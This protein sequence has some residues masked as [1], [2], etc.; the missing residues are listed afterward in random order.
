MSV[1]F[2]PVDTLKGIGAVRSKQLAGMG[3]CTLYDLLSYFPRS[4]EDRTVFTSIASLEPDVRGCFR[5]MVVSHPQTA[6][7]KKGMEITKVSVSDDTKKL[8][9]VFFNQSYISKQ[10]EYGQEYAFYGKLDAGYTGLQMASPSFEPLGKNEITGRIF[11]IYPLSAGISN[12]IMSGIVIQSLDACRGELPDI[13]P[14]S[15]RSLNGLDDVQTAY[16]TVHYPPNFPALDRAKNRLVFE[17]FFVFSV[18]LNLMKSARTSIF[19]SPYEMVNLDPFYGAL[20]FSLTNAQRCATEDIVS[21]FSQNKPM[22]RLIQGDVGSGKTMVAAAAIYCAVKNGQQVA[23]MAPTSILA[24][25][26][27]KSLK[28]LLG[29]FGITVELL[30]S[31]LKA[32]EKKRVKSAIASG[33]ASVV[34]GTHALISEDVLFHNLDLVIADEQ[35]RFG[36]AQRTALSAKGA[37]PH[38]L[39]MSATPIPRTLSLMVYGD[40]DVSVMGELPSGRQPIDTFLMGESMRARINAFIRKQVDAHNQVF[41]VCPAVEESENETL[42]SAQM[43]SEALQ[44]IIFPD[45]DV[46]LLHGQMKGLEKEAIMDK[47]VLGKTDILVATTVIEVGVDVPN[48]TLMVIENAERFGL[49][50]LHQLRGRVGRGTDKSYCIL[51]TQS[52]NEETRQ[53]LNALVG[54]NDGFKIADEDLRL[55]GPGDFF[56][57]RQHGLPVFK[58]ANLTTDLETLRQ[59]QIAAAQ[60]L[61]SHD[62][63]DDFSK[64]ALQARIHALFGGDEVPIS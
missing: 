34:V 57:S 10:L 60:Y 61:Q 49:S 11:P 7:I 27:A 63:S 54:T 12:K 26:H 35:H 59:A 47:F 14:T 19:H 17:E 52:R 25:Q 13:V 45:L 56:G 39:V 36:V 5:A 15:L 64:K 32:G 53:R 1:L 30:T 37:H 33:E 24:Q 46:A 2:D 8:T 48:A 23:F 21:D 41:I 55:R 62:S 51:M 29:Q 4:Y 28:P 16:D 18:A 44:E 43:W 9:L 50:Q 38:L 20:P 42:K 40:L 31:S 22:N 6:R 58:V 3:I